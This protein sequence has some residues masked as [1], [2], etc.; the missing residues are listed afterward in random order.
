MYD[1]ELLFFFKNTPLSVSF[2]VKVR[3]EKTVHL[4]LY[5]NIILGEAVK[6]VLFL[7]ARLLRGGGMGKGLATKKKELFLKALVAGPLKTELFMK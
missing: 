7:M 1:L 4:D 3:K 2:D 5:N 6:K